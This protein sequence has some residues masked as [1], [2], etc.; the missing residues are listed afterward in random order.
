MQVSE[1]I[2]ITTDILRFSKDEIPAYLTRRAKKPVRQQAAEL[3]KLYQKYRFPPYHYLKHRMYWRAFD[4]DPADYPPPEL[5]HRVRDRLNPRH[6]IDKAED[7]VRF[8]SVM[9]EAGVPVPRD[10]FLIARDGVRDME[11]G[12]L[13]LSAAAGRL[14][15]SGVRSVFIKPRHGGMGRFTFKLD[16]KPDGLRHGSRI[17]TESALASLL[18]SWKT[19]ARW[20]EFLV[21]D[22][23]EQHPV[24]QA[25]NSAAVNTIRIDTLVEGGTVRHNGAALRVGSGVG[26]TDNWAK[27]GFVVP[28]DL[29]SG[30]LRGSAKKKAKF[31]D[32]SYPFHPA[33]GFVFDGATLPYWAEVKDMVERAALALRPLRSIG[34]DVAIGAGGPVVIEA[35]HDYDIG[36]LQDV[37]GGLRE[38]PLGRLLAREDR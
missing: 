9:K 21:Q 14:A 38:T 3:R 7:K 27:G 18:F 20:K 22:T 5:L 17:V 25:M 31:S 15:A 23:V 4:G 26:V 33:S 29:E 35:N 2:R 24:L 1:A 16:V 30:R 34:W 8:A 32:R 13:P 10:L 19:P 11:G 37:V 36:M 12:S 6:A 28:I